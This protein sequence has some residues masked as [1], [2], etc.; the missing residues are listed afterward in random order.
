MEQWNMGG[1]SLQLLE[2]VAE[3][4]AQELQLTRLAYWI[5]LLIAM[6]YSTLCTVTA[7]SIC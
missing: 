1:R 2:V 7:P 6:D 3:M 5:S 4:P